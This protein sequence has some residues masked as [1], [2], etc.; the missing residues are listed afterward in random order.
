MID[1]KKPGSMRKAAVVLIVGAILMGIA[2]FAPTEQGTTA[3][4]LKIITGFIGFATLCFGAYLR[5]A[6]KPA[7]GK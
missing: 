6:K 1:V 7:E 4:T 5:P 3:H 2:I